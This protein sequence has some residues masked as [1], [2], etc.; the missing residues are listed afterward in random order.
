MALMEQMVLLRT[1]DLKRTLPNAVPQSS[2]NKPTY[3]HI[4][5][6]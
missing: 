1:A 6:R 4:S 5:G 2:R 3:R